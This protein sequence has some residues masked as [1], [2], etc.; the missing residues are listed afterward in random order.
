MVEPGRNRRSFCGLVKVSGD[1]TGLQRSCPPCCRYAG[2]DRSDLT[3]QK[4]RYQAF[5]EATPCVTVRARS[6]ACVS[7]S[8]SSTRP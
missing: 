4:R 6:T 5:C 8:L 7:S 2:A 1:F 3:G